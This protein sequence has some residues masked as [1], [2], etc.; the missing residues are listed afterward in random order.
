[1]R[2]AGVERGGDLRSV[3]E[4]SRGRGAMHALHHRHAQS[5]CGA[6]QVFGTG[7]H[8]LS[9]PPRQQITQK[10]RVSVSLFCGERSLL[11][12]CSSC[13]I[14]TFHHDSKV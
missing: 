3:A 6:G 1:M 13:V 4:L 14:I 8:Q 7:C 9:G 2:L 5:P 11:C 12:G 10:D